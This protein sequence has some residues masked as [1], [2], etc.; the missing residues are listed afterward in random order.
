MLGMKNIDIDEALDR[1]REKKED[2]QDYIAERYDNVRDVVR[3]TSRAVRKSP[4]LA[5][6]TVASVAMLMGY[7]MGARRARAKQ[8]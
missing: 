2:V 6:G 1:V 8:R 5:L 3:H 4:F 7:I